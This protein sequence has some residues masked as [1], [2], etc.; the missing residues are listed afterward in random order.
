[1]TQPLLPGI[2]LTRTITVVESLTVPAVSPAFA[3]FRDMPPV[4]ATAFLIG[5]IESTCIEALRPYLG[6]GRQ[7]VGTHVDVSHA[8]A[9]PA[10]MTVT[11]HVEL[12]EVQG[13]KLRFRVTCRDDSDLVGEGFHERA[14]IDRAK[15]IDR[16][17]AKAAAQA[18]GKRTEQGK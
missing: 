7:T 4:F 11:A 9:T 15:F 8:A 17:A 3:G 12:I 14:V 10:G 2:S 5:F 18:N 6:E 13:R 1:M 16:A